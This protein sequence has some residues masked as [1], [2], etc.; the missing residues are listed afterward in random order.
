MRVRWV[1]WIALLSLNAGAA[2]PIS[3]ADSAFRKQLQLRLIQAQPG[4]VIELPAGKWTLNRSLSLNKSGVTLRGAGPNATILSFRGQ[5][6]GA[7][8]LIVNGA[9]HVTIENLA[10]EDPKGDGL[11]VNGCK[12]VIL[13]NLRVEWTQGPNEKNGAY[14]LYPVQSERVLIERSVAIGAS[15]AGI[16]AGQSKYVVI[17]DN[18][19]A[20][21]VA[22]M[23]VENSSH[24]DVYRNEVTNNAG[25]VLVFNVPGVPV[26]DGRRTRVFDN[27]I[28]SNNTQNFTPRANLIFAVPAGTGFMVLANA[29]VEI[30]N[31]KVENNQTA[32]ALLL[33]FSA[34]GKPSNDAKFDPYPQQLWIHD[35]QFIGGGD[36][37]DPVNTRILK[38]GK[39]SSA[40]RLPDILWDGSTPGA[41]AELQ[42]CIRSNGDAD[43]A[44]FDLRG[45]SGS[46]SHDMKPHDCALAPLPAVSWPGLDGATA[47]LVN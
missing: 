44:N 6:Q 33:A 17:R 27:H 23:E 47:A 35:N 36:K 15:E 41:G 24:V 31:N 19:V 32:N 38:L 11:K 2:E 46:I 25:G 10:I 26:K 1:A 3:D 28:H 45:R 16:Y 40:G 4:E 20:F 12:D 37:P 21:N 9:S 7:E 30:F 42:I 34:T 22:G 39:L 14:G 29:E 5:G 18:R 13:R 8:G 43:F